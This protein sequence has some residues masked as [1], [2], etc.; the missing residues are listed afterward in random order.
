VCDDATVMGN[1]AIGG[2]P[3]AGYKL[4]VVGNGLICYQC[5]DWRYAKGKWKSYKWWQIL[6]QL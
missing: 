4:K 3:H 6:F 5:W 2:T 1:A